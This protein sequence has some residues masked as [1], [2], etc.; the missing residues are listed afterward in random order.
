MVAGH[1]S[2]RL[3]TL[4][5]QVCLRMHLDEVVIPRL[6]WVSSACVGCV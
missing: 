1:V 4:G 2:P 3:Q 5:S 6:H